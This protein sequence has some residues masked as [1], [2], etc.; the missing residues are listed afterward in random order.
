MNEVLA[1]GRR[2]C[3]PAIL[4]LCRP[5]S[6]FRP[7]CCHS[8][9]AHDLTK[10]L[11]IVL[12]SIALYEAVFPARDACQDWRSYKR[13]NVIVS[14]TNGRWFA[15]RLLLWDHRAAVSF[16]ELLSTATFDGAWL[17]ADSLFEVLIVLLAVKVDVQGAAFHALTAVLWPL[18]AYD[19]FVH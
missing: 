11:C 14:A 7:R 6:V 18:L 12:P 2:S 5:C 13:P 1:A 9:S 15:R 8:G 17:R 16:L 4:L 19:S 3:R 10:E